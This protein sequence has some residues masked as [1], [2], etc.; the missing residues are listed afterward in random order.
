ML[1]PWAKPPS[2]GC[3]TWIFAVVAL[4]G[5]L[6]S[7][8]VPLSSIFKAI[9]RESFEKDD[10]FLSNFEEKAQFLDSPRKRSYMIYHHFPH[11]SDHFSAPTILFFSHTPLAIA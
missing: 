1:S 9:A 7:A 5:L 11:F 2:P 10:G 6:D 8:P 4:I 3:L